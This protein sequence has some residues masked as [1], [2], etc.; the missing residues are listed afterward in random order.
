MRKVMKN[1]YLWNGSGEPDP[2]LQRIEKSLAQFRYAGEMPNFPLM[3]S[4]RRKQSLFAFLS[5]GWAP[6]FAAAT[7]LVLALVAFG[8]IL[9]ISPPLFSNAPSWDVARL[10]GT[11]HVGQFMLGMD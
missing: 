1:D 8:F 5:T 7:L 9:R 2:E 4:G 11:Q 3:D 10:S 6:R